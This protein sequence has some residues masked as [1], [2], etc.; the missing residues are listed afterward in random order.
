MMVNAF[1]LGIITLSVRGFDTG[2]VADPILNFLN[3]EGLTVDSIFLTHTH[4]DHVA[5]PVNSKGG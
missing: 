1:A 2:P 4:R 5:C 3:K